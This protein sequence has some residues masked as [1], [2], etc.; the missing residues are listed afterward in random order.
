[1][2]QFFKEVSDWFRF[3]K[4]PAADKRIVFFHE[5]RQ[6]YGYLEGLLRTLTETHGETVYYITSEP[7]DPILEN[8]PDGVQS[9]FFNSLLAVV[10]GSIQCRVFVMT[11]TD[12][13]HFY[14]KRSGH[15]VHYVYIYHSLVST[16]MIYRYGAFD[17]YDTILC[18]GPHQN[19][20]IRK[21]EALNGVPEKQLVNAGYF[22]LETIYAAFHKT[23]YAD[24]PPGNIILI[25]PSWGKQNI[26]ESVGEQL[27]GMLLKENYRVIVRPHPETV[28]RTPEIIERIRNRFDDAALTIEMSVA[29]N[30]SL[31]KA[32]V[33]I[34]DYSGVSLEYA[35]GTN[36]PVL[37]LD[38]PLKINND[39]YR[40]IELP[41]LELEA[42]SKIG[43]I[44]SPDEIDQVPRTIERLKT[45]RP[46]FEK[47]IADIRKEYVYAF[48][49]SSEIGAEHIIKLLNNPS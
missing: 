32:D 21:H 45:E 9:F 37:F 34:S 25:A 40:E 28:K 36:R 42:R 31:F 10:L 33:L 7:T 17:H 5:N 19:R 1:M 39:R 24:T 49:H 22:R 46:S 30:D 11:M 29:T 43:I 16:H 12:L 38:V 15:P 23:E 44:L 27:V 20:E 4:I 35:L 2:K 26:L 47:Q 14:L 6:Y 13:N 48:G 18:V 41:T 3:R 8:P